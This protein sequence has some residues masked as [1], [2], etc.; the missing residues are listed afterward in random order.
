MLFLVKQPGG[1][2]LQSE[3][4]YVYVYVYVGMYYGLFAIHSDLSA[5]EE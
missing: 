5:P 1:Q 2:L 3:C 4:I